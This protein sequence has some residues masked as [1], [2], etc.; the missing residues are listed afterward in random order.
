MNFLLAECAPEELVAYAP[1]HLSFSWEKDQL[2]YVGITK[3][4]ASVVVEGSKEAELLT[5]KWLTSY[6]EGTIL[7]LPYKQ[8]PTQ[9]SRH[10]QEA[11][12]EI[13]LGTT[14][15]YGAIASKIG[16]AKASRAV[17]RACGANPMPLVIPCHR[18]LARDA[19]L[20]GFNRGLDIKQALLTLEQ[21]IQSGRAQGYC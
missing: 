3:G 10:V 1:F 11:M 15:S 4:E 8:A 21:K 17:G 14:Q 5:K 19:S 7:P 20:C 13:P 9:F 18:V 2:C 16:R 12:L 6:F